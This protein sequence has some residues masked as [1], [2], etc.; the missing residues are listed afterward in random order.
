MNPQGNNEGFNKQGDPK[1]YW[2]GEAPQ[3]ING[4]L[5]VDINGI[6]HYPELI[7]S[8]VLPRI[9]ERIGVDVRWIVFQLNGIVYQTQGFEFLVYE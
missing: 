9:S 3:I 4:K 6:S 8:K 5:L 7:S 2:F 1:K